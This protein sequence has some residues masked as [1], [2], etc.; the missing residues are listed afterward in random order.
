MA[1]R[2]QRRG[3]GSL[4]A[5]LEGEMVREPWWADVEL[6]L[7]EIPHAVIGGV[8]VNSYMAPRHTKDLDVGVLIAELP[9]AEGRL[10]AAGWVRI[11]PT[12]PTDPDLSGWAWRGPSRHEVDLFGLA[13]AWA[14]RAIAE[15]EVSE[16]TGLPTLGAEY[17]VLMKITVGRT[18]DLADLT[19]LLGA[20]GGDELERIRRVVREFQPDDLADVERL[21]RLGQ[22]ERSDPGEQGGSD[23]AWEGDD[24]P[25]P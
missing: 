11:G 3:Y 23:R 2:R 20:R 24:H 4:L 14:Q 21:I 13:H 12:Q 16:G 8:A 1:V 18:S 25:A 9:L 6:A 7:S 17:L 22:M 15:V 19:R 5:G 10:E